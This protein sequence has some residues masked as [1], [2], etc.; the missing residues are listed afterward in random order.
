MEKIF[1]TKL[2]EQKRY[3]KSS[4]KNIA[5]ESS[6]IPLAIK[7]DCRDSPESL[8]E[9]DG[10]SDPKR[11]CR[12]DGVND[13]EFRKPPLSQGMLAS[14]G[15][16]KSEIIIDLPGE[17]LAAADFKPFGNE[18][19]DTRSRLRKM[20]NELNPHLIGLDIR[21]QLRSRKIEVSP[22]PVRYSIHPGLGPEWR[23]P[24]LYPKTGKKK[25][26][27]DWIDLERLDEGE[28]LN[29]T[30]VA[31]YLRFL[32]H[33]LE[34]KSASLA[35]KIYFFNTFFFASLTNTPKGKKGINYEAVKNWTRSIDI[36]SYDY[37]VVPI[38][39]SQH[40]YLAIICNAAALARTPNETEDMPKDEPPLSPY[41]PISSVPSPTHHTSPRAIISI[42]EKASHLNKTQ[43]LDEQDPS[44]SFA[45]LSLETPHKSCTDLGNGACAEQGATNTD[46][47]FANQNIA[48]EQVQGTQIDSKDPER[49]EIPS[50]DATVEQ[51]YDN[52]VAVQDHGPKAPASPKKRKR[53]SIPPI[54]RTDPTSPLIITF[55]SL[56]MSHPSTIRILKDYLLAEG[57]AKRGMEVDLSRIRGLTA[58]QIPQQTNY[59]DC[60]LFL[61]GYIDKFLDAP[62]EFISKIIG[63][64][65]SIEKDW[66]KLNPSNLRA[67]M[68]TQLQAL[69]AAEEDERRE[70]AK[71]ANKYHSKQSQEAQSPSKDIAQPASNPTGMSASLLHQPQAAAHP[72][73]T[74]K[75]ALETAL[76]IDG[77]ETRYAK[78]IFSKNSKQSRERHFYQDSSDPLHEEVRE[79]SA[80]RPRD[81][82]FLIVIESQSNEAGNEAVIDYAEPV[83]NSSSDRRSVSVGFPSEIQDSQPSSFQ[84]LHAAVEN[85]PE[86]PPQ[87]S[88]S[89]SKD[90]Y[91][92]D[93]GYPTLSRGA[94]PENNLESTERH[95][96]SEFKNS[97][98]K[99]KPPRPTTPH[100]IVEIDD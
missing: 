28:Y 64:E 16:A 25:I 58:K 90:Q 39:E 87:T 41:D 29:D 70:K 77:L 97:S 31:F 78:D 23:K 100:E 43:E 86:T 54:Q 76:P 52:Q 46:D 40:W 75:Q 79:V 80:P 55:D 34:E 49:R 89:T 71:N 53:K 26:S 95:A 38:N 81:E 13:Q 22:P 18:Q 73:S 57:K 12:P 7:N 66:P 65:Y 2:S 99:G 6:F 85:I 32:E 82:P 35:K 5:A 21:P 33:Q 59:C 69:H 47:V 1:E 88:D 37:I 3:T 96:N 8:D 20:R 14:T 15:Q 27:V 61:L 9:L 42:E 44:A 51:V 91:V 67:S 74:R 83:R 94:E 24:L 84:D 19:T 98:E 56:S 11:R 30:L 17:S 93:S 92:A 45:D 63:H 10:P 48:D 68:R 72:P 60:G 50:S 62:K 36:F 4:R